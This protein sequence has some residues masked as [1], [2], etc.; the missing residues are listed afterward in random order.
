MMI[1]TANIIGRATSFV[2]APHR[3]QRRLVAVLLFEAMDGVLHH[4]DRAV[5]DHPEVDRA[6]AHQVGADAEQRA[7]RES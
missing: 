3:L 1:T 7:C 6:E 5:D 2:A 4:H